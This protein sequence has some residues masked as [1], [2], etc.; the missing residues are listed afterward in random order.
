MSIPIIGA[1]IDGVVEFFKTR[2]TIKAAKDQRKDE[3]KKLDLE[4]KLAT[5]ERAQLSDLEADSLARKMA[6]YMDDI[7]FYLFLAP[8]VLVFHPDMVEHVKNGFAAL[9]TLPEWWKYS[10]GLML[11]S[12]WGYKRLVTPIIEQVIKAKLKFIK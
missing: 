1:V 6:G 7:S 9:D 3:L 12:V 11:A 10:L 2:Q 5:I 8:L 4:K